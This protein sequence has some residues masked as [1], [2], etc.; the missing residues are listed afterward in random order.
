MRG[1]LLTL[2]TLC[3]EEK[4]ALFYFKFNFDTDKNTQMFFKDSACL[5]M[6]SVQGGGGSA[7]LL[8]AYIG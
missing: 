2:L 5:I 3:V 4:D 6:E 7:Q 8:S 1:F